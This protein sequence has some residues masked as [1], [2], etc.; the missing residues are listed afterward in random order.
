[1][2]NQLVL[3]QLLLGQVARVKVHS[4]TIECTGKW[5][6]LTSNERLSVLCENNMADL[7]RFVIVKTQ[8]LLYHSSMFCDP[9]KLCLLLL[10]DFRE[11]CN[12]PNI[13]DAPFVTSSFIHYRKQLFDLYNE[14]Q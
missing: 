2:S 5:L 7:R 3:R 1:M 9:G 6:F 4:T 10:K 8:P 13:I 12:S 14:L 11:L